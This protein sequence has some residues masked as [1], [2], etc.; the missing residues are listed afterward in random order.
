MYRALVI[1]AL[2]VPAAACASAQAK[3]PVEPIS[4][5]VPAVPPRVVDTVVIDPP[6]APPVEEPVQ[7][8][9]PPPSTKTQRPAR[10]RP[11]ARTDPKPD[12]DPEPAAPP[13]AAPAPVPPL[14]T[15]G[16]SAS[17][18]ETKRQIM[19]IVQRARGMLDGMD[20]RGMSDDRLANYESAKDS[21]IRAE[22]A[23]KASNLVLARQIADRAENIAKQLTSR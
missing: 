8:P 19:E 5:E 15:G 1:A 12:P 2:T 17:T 22:A 21:I 18:D 14:R 7:A 3:T 13:A 4:L 11:E 23:L 6:P 20:T 16:Q 9:T 10:D